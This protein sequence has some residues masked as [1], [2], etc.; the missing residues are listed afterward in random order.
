MIGDAAAHDARARDGRPRHFRRVLGIAADAFFDVLLVD[1]NRDERAGGLCLRG[2]GEGL[3]FER[4]GFIAVKTRGFLHE[5]H[6]KMRGRQMRQGFG[7]LRL[8]R[9]E[10]R[11]GFFL[12]N[13]EALFHA[14]L[15]LLPI[16]FARDRLVEQREGGGAQVV[17]RRD[18][19]DRAFAKSPVGALLRAGQDPVGAWPPTR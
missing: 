10:K 16:R 17:R 8:G 3:G 11:G 6:G 19:I 12:G 15:P 4:Q 2:L 7:G 14:G 9:G 5:V 13:P 1:E 18:G